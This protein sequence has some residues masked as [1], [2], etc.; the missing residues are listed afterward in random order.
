[1]LCRHLFLDWGGTLMAEDGPPDLP[2]V[3]WPHPR[4]LPGTLEAVAQLAAGRPLSLCTNAAVSTRPQIEAAL[5]RAGLLPFFTHVFSFSELGARKDSPAFWDAVFARVALPRDQ[6]L[7]VG[8]SLD[9]DVLAP[10]RFGVPSVWFNPQG[11]APPPGTPPVRMV[12]SLAEL[13]ALL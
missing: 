9:Q 11:L 4:L 10:Q 8:D 1:M 2:T 5:A 6:T 7:M 3:Q 12:R 13:G